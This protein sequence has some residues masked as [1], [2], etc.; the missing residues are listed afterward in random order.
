MKQIAI[1]ILLM[2]CFNSLQAQ[3]C[4]VLLHTI[5]ESYS[6][7]C[8]KG[9]AHGQ[10]IAKGTDTYNGQFKKGL[11]NGFG[12]YTWSNGNV[13]EGAFKK[14]K[15][16]G[17]GKLTFKNDSIITGFWKKDVY[18]GL[19]EKPYTKIDKSQNVSAFNLVKVQDD[20]NSLRFYVKINQKYEKSPHMN[21]VVHSGQ[22][23]SQLNNNDFVELTNVIFPI[24]L[25]A[26]YKQDFIEIEI[27]QPGLWEIRT[28][29]TLMKGLNTQN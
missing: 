26:Y 8:K 7:D 13:Y 16:E 24:K 22:Y 2:L 1:S 25:K 5:N 18:L 27:F 17:Q 21:I 3:N 6:G 23:Q 9:K 19:F 15:K 12:T 11:P 14:G 10:G 4:K 20:M 29:I 28:D